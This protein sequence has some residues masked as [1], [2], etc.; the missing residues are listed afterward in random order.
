VIGF[1]FVRYL[2]APELDW[3]DELEIEETIRFIQNGLS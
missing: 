3:D 2:M 1:L